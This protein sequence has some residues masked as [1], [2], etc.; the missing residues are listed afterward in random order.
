MDNDRLESILQTL[1][2]LQNDVTNCKSRLALFES[3]LEQ[4]KTAL[5]RDCITDYDTIFLLK[6]EDIALDSVNEE[7]TIKPSNEA[8]LPTNEAIKQPNEATKP[9][10]DTSSSGNVNSSSNENTEGACYDPDAS[11]T[12]WKPSKDFSSLLEKNFRRKLSYNHVLDVL[13]TNSVLSVDALASPTLDLAIIN[14]ISNPLSKKY[15]QNVVRKWFLSSVLY[16]TRLAPC[17]V[18]MMPLN[19]MTILMSILKFMLEQALCLLGSANYQIA[20]NKAKVNLGDLPLPNAK[21]MLFGDD[22]PS[23]TSKQADLSRG[24]SKNLSSNARRE[25]FS[26][27]QRFGSRRVPMR[28]SFNSG[29]FTSSKYSPNRPKNRFFRPQ[30]TVQQESTSTYLSGSK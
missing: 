6:S 12:S 22:F 15:V 14:Q 26:S 4:Q 11:V 17:V 2:S 9:S 30:R 24:L 5:E 10:N 20:I 19:R 25:F 16:L 13:E 23:L 28:S 7:G 21:R 1:Q 8:E 3:R 27:T 18:Y 29:S